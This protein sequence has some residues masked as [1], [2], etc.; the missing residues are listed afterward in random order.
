ME[1]ADIVH[2][3]PVPADQEIPPPVMGDIHVEAD[4]HDNAAEAEVVGNPEAQE[5]QAHGAEEEVAGDEGAQ[6]DEMHED[7]NSQDGGES[8]QGD[9]PEEVVHYLNF[10]RREDQLLPI[11]MRNC[12]RS[13]RGRC[14]WDG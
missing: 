1:G 12:L 4:G 6:G 8:A 14:E 2:E 9:E 3:I 7:H 11:A 5:A 13:C 10:G